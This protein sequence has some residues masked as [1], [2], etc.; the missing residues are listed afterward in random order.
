MAGY[1]FLP[2]D[3]QEMREFAENWQEGQR[4]NG[5]SPYTLLC[6]SSSRLQRATYG[7]ALRML[8]R[9]DKLYVLAHGGEMGSRRIGARRGAQRGGGPVPSWTGGELKTYTP[10]QLAALMV[11][12]GLPWNIVDVRLFICG[13]GLGP[14]VNGVPYRPFA[15]RFRDEMLMRGYSDI[16]VT[17]YLGSVR[18]SYAPRADAHGF[19]SDPTQHKG[20]EAPDL[21]SIHRASEYKQRF[22]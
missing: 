20:I 18:S 22:F 13:S 6:N 4:R 3:T 5:K 10:E 7:G 11:N 14:T 9:A 17:G 1:I 15:E 8:T 12:E 21:P 16:R 19:L 2:V